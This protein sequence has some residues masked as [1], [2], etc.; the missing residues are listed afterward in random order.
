MASTSEW[1][2][3]REIE[4]VAGTPPGGGQDRPA[5]A[6]IEVLTAHDLLGQPVKLTNIP[7]RGGGNAWDYLRTKN[8]DPHVLAISSPTIISN[9]LMGVSDFDYAELTPLAN[10]YTEYPVFIV[11]ADSSIS[12]VAALIRRLKAD[13]AGVQIALATAIGNTNHIALARLTQ[14]A[15]GDV[16]ALK[17]DV[18]DSARYA[19]GHVVEGKA[20][21]GVITAVSA[22]PELTAGKLKAV[23]LSGPQR[24]GGV[25][26]ETPTLIESGVDCQVGMW[27][28]IVAASGLPPAAIAFWD[29]TL[30]KATAAELWRTELANKYWANT[31]MIGAQELSFLDE[32]RRLTQAALA[33][34]GLL[35]VKR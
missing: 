22:V 11:R 26:A 35:P 3:T 33:E 16:K 20:E 10:L 9:K 27:R 8:G 19:I 28:G 25:F 15:G 18:F 7:G 5:R 30:A 4:L 6:L 2:P 24:L 21:L 32:D 17:I 31:F 23:V 29:D 14:H 12:D 1:R 34:L 13:T